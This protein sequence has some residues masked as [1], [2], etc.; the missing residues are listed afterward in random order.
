MKLNEDKCHVSAFGTKYLGVTIN[1]GTIELSESESEKLL[2]IVIDSILS[3]S[4]H[5]NQLCV[6]QARDYMQ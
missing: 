5:V 3:F 4:H 2:G 6:K 1:I